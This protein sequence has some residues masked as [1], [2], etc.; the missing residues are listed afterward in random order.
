MPGGTG[1]RRPGGGHVDPADELAVEPV[2]ADQPPQRIGGGLRRAIRCRRVT[3]TEPRI[4]AVLGIHRVDASDGDQQEP[5][6]QPDRGHQEHQADNGLATAG[7]GEAQ[8]KTDHGAA[9][10][11]VLT[12]PSRTMTSRSA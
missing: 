3:G 12:F 4:A 10:V 6:A 2:G 9:P 7:Q 1:E 5:D 8:A 11:S